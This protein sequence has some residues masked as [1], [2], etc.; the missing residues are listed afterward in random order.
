MPKTWMPLIIFI[1]VTLVLFSV[2]EIYEAFKSEKN[3]G[4]YTVYIREI[5]PS[6]DVDLIRKVSEYQEKVLVKQDEIST[7]Q[8]RDDEQLIDTGV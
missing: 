7:D 1:V 8:D 4:Q 6:I 5:S 2:W 3:V